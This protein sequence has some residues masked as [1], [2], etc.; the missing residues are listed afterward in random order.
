MV[1]TTLLKRF[2]AKA[3]W[4]V[5]LLAVFISAPFAFA[6][7]PRQITVVLER[8]GSAAP[9]DVS[10]VLF[11]REA[12]KVGERLLPYFTAERDLVFLRDGPTERTVWLAP[13][14]YRVIGASADGLRGHVEWSVR[15]KDQERLVLR[16]DPDQQRP[17][18]R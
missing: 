4:L 8:E 9:T 1:S 5:C 11:L 15:V 17:F 6:S 7:T 12:I 14:E 10:V 2:G 3:F 18:Y 16:F 13:G